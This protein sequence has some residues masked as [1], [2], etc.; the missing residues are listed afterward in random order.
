MI[1]YE[2]ASLYGLPPGVT[3][4]T[5][6]EWLPA[7]QPRDPTQVADFR[8][9]EGGSGRMAA[10]RPVTRGESTAAAKIVLLDQWV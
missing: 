5:E 2:N 4:I 1:S 10:I 7:Y 9:S 8:G 6:A 3:E